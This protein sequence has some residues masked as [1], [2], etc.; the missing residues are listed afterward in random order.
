MET[1]TT[2]QTME[3]ED[4]TA[5]GQSPEPSNG[6]YPMEVRV[7]LPGTG[8]SMMET[9]TSYSMVETTQDSTPPPHN[10]TRMKRLSNWLNKIID[11]RIKALLMTSIAILIIVAGFEF[12]LSGQA[13]ARAEAQCTT[14]IESRSDLR[15]VLFKVVDLSDLFV[16]T[17][18]TPNAAVQAYTQNRV[19]FINEKYPPINR[20]DC[21]L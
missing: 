5:A 20:S 18:K 2:E 21:D 7:V 11:V 14:R 4:Q 16:G 1:V 3:Q 10:L 19:D 13:T 12:Q 17:D 8:P 9:G 15:E 6:N